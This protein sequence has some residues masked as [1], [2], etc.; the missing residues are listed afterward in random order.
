VK[1]PA[2]PTTRVSETVIVAGVGARI[3]AATARRF[4]RAGY[5]VGLFARSADRIEALADDLGDGA[6]AV[7]TDVTDD[8][9][10]RAGVEEVREEFGP[11]SVLVCNASGGG[12]NPVEEA[13]AERAR[14]IF[15]VRVAGSLALV[16]AARAD[17]RETNGTVLFSGTTFADPPVADQVEWGAVAPAAE[18]LA[19][20]LDDALDGVA[21]TY[22]R[23]G[24]GVAP[25]GEGGPARVGADRVADRY[26]ALAAD[27]ALGTPVVEV[28]Q[29]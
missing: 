13:T 23:I 11:I 25:A 19:R 15:D 6:L 10:V 3:G 28:R 27:D 22:V 21:V 1:S 17:L 12:G 7:P 24:T 8:A 14:E 18:G 29:R 2:V 16:Q 5:D 20:T 26:L 4:H 9:D